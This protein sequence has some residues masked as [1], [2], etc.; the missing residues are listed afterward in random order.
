MDNQNILYI[1]T[2]VYLIIFL[3][4]KHMDLRFRE[5]QLHF[6]YNV[7][8]DKSFNLLKLQFSH[9][10]NGSNKEILFIVLF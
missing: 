7:D 6:T 8:L 3:V 5:L 9:L 2:C 1:H 10:Q 4:A